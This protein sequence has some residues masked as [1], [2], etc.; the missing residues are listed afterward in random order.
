MSSVSKDVD[1]SQYM[2]S[3]ARIIN[4]LDRSTNKPISLKIE[5]LNLHDE[6]SELTLENQNE[7]AKDRFP[8]FKHLIRNLTKK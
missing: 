1:L 4:T 5:S 7:I 8:I 6:F 3:I 2:P